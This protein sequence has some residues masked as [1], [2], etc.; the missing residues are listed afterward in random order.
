M[1]KYP[2]AYETFEE[3]GHKE[4]IKNRLGQARNIRTLESK[5]QHDIDLANT[6]LRG[7]K[8]RGIPKK[9]FKKDLV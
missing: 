6:L 7:E 9:E 2:Y 4:A 3:E 8:P 1:H 5:Y